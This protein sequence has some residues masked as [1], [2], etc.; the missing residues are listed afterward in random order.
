MMKYAGNLRTILAFIVLVTILLTSTMVPIQQ[1]QAQ[2]DSYRVYLPAVL[3]G[4]QT[5]QD[6]CLPGDLQWLCLLNQ[7]RT[8]AGLAS[9]LPDLD[10]RAGLALHNN[11]LLLNPDQEN[12]HLE[13]PSNPGYT[14]EGKIAGSQSNMAKKASTDFQVLETMDLWMKFSSHR[15]NMLHPD[16]TLS[17]FDLSC[18]N[19][20]CYS[21]LN[22]LGSLP[23]S[24][25]VTEMNVRYPGD[26]QTGIPADIFPVTWGFYMPWTDQEDDSD[27]VYLINADIYNQQN[28]KISITTTE[29]N[30][31]DGAW[32]Y[33]NQVSLNA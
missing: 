18:D 15:Y 16:L 17:G 28:Q 13:Y 9:V 23:A 22:V 19:S 5:S 25:Q 2:V 20:N 29:P 30:H 32:D 26:N 10:Y 4:N 24:Y 14:E 7:Y 12:F 8:A 31:T 1:V 11:Y 27:E 6:V 3:K 33:K 21:G